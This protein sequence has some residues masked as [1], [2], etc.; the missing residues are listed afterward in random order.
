MHL[1]PT[2]FITNASYD[3]SHCLR[4]SSDMSL[5]RKS[6][7]LLVDRARLLAHGIAYLGTMF[8]ACA[9]RIPGPCVEQLLS[10]C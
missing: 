6:I 1:V 5:T 4:S 3:V 8:Y 2:I 9:L 10:H 7:H